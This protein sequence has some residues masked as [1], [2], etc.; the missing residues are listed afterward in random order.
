VSKITCTHKDLETFSDLRQQHIKRYE[1]LPNTRMDIQVGR[2]YTT[3]GMLFRD[4]YPWF[5]IFGDSGSFVP[6]LVAGDYLDIE[7]FSL[8]PNWKI[9]KWSVDEFETRIQFLD[10]S[11]HG[12]PDFFHRAI[13]DDQYILDVLCKLKSA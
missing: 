11:L 4:N 1:V 9:S 5:Y 12:D 10:N 13:M 6:L 8:P 3:I 2:S 7:G